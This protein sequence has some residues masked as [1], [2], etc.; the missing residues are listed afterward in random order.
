MKK[1]IV[2]VLS[3]LFLFA[4]ERES[5]TRKIKLSDEAV[6]T[7]TNEQVI[8]S[9]FL[10]SQERRSIA[11]MFFQNLTGDQRLEWL[12]EGLT[13]MFIR[14]L[15]QSRSL[16]VLS[17]ER[18]FE[19]LDRIEVDKTETIGLD[20]A[21]VVAREANVEAVLTGNIT[22][23][24]DSL[25]I[26]V[27]LHEPTR[28]MILKEESIEGPGLERIFAMVDHLTHRIK[29]DLQVAL[30][31]AEP[32]KSIAELSTNSLDA[33]RYYT[34]GIE[35]YNKL[36]YNEAL[37]QF[38]KAVEADS[39][40]LSA[41]LEM[42][43]QYIQTGRL[44]E[45]LATIQHLRKYEDQMAPLDVY[46]LKILNAQITQDFTGYFET[47]R[48][49]LEQYPDDR[50]ANRDLANIYY[51]MHNYEQAIHYYQKS[52]EIDPR[53]KLGLNQ[54][55][56]IYALTGKFEQAVAT[57]EKYLE[58]AQDEPNPYDSL[59][60]I[61]FYA[62]DYKKAEKNFKKALKMNE[63]F[64]H[65]LLHLADVYLDNGSYEKVIDLLKD[66]AEEL[67]DINQKINVYN[68]L[69]IAHWRLG[70]I[71]QALENFGNSL[72]TVEFV[73]DVIE[74]TREL[75]V[76][77]YGTDRAQEYLLATYERL[78]EKYLEF[79]IARGYLAC[80]SLLSFWNDVHPEESIRL[81]EEAVESEG[82]NAT[83]I[84]RYNF[85]RTLL[86]MKSDRQQELEKLS[87]EIP[88][89]FLAAF[90]ETRNFSY[91][92]TMQYFG[93][94]SEFLQTDVNA[95]IEKF[96][97]FIDY[98]V[99]NN[100]IITEMIFRLYTA[101][102]YLHSN[103]SEEYKKELVAIGMPAEEKWLVIGPFE[104]KNGFHRKYQPEKRVKITEECEGKNQ[105][106]S[107][108]HAVDSIN[109]GYINLKKITTNMNWGVGYGAMIIQSPDEKEVYLRVGANG[110]I[111]LWL[112]RKEVWRFSDHHDAIFDDYSVK[113]NLRKGNNS[114]LL[115]VCNRVGECGF[116]FRVTDKDG[117]GIPDIDFLA[118]DHEV[119]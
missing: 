60:E 73:Y 25:Q 90:Q 109:D 50:D 27:R 29:T 76:E 46:R 65:S 51:G 110:P 63:R 97:K 103:K 75:Y 9:I 99:E 47:I 21:A 118:V 17:T 30:D 38:S 68:N 7:R 80:M 43:R 98:S 18:V 31:K 104:N 42:C 66:S 72:Q 82:L 3:M 74:L 52:L 100:L 93:A 78:K 28:G 86:Y 119:S 41:Q 71:D 11:V 81:L 5:E 34:E 64:Y 94:M 105:M 55:G 102:L 36:M 2:I 87:G 20:M 111:K 14:T 77:I 114:I 33:W 79:G 57:L 106:V 15:S 49:R 40:F 1:I 95:G 62:G 108:Q 89:V 39:M 101:N 12:Q 19:I 113:V 84:A 6:S 13:E 16:S 83:L 92:S 61:Y 88:D 67:E 48:E 37:Q 58:V 23:S 53:Y 24:G 69:A 91:E 54:L 44:N 59:G 107:W 56:Y 85:F 116:Y 115:K 70:N 45:A 4:C 8:T 112:N 96:S 26:S 35:F 32:D 10:E 22:K 117:R